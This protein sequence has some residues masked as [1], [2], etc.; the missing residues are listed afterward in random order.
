MTL[1]RHREH[2]QSGAGVEPAVTVGERRERVDRVAR[3]PE[4]T[5]VVEV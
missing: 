4:V 1:A 2:A 5:T 3:L